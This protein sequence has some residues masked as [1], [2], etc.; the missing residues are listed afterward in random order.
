MIVTLSHTKPL[1]TLKIEGLYTT[2]A[3]TPPLPITE[4]DTSITRNMAWILIAAITIIT[5]GFILKRYT[6]YTVIG[7]VLHV[8]SGLAA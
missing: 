6:S 3:P 7:L 8:F 1:N 5:I 2:K 4:D